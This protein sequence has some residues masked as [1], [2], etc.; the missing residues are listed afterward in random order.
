M[1]ERKMAAFRLRPAT[2]ERLRQLA[3][4][5]HRTMT[6]QIEHMI[7]A[8]HSFDNPDSPART[9]TSITAAKD[10]WANASDCELLAG[11]CQDATALGAYSATL[12]Y[13]GAT[14]RGLTS[15]QFAA[16][17]A[18]RDPMALDDLQ[19]SGLS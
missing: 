19:W 5:E 1:I 13:E 16:I 17:M 7:N 15:K 10:G 12:L 2:I 8:R 4:S 9:P 3:A 6:G 18:S 11:L 14:K